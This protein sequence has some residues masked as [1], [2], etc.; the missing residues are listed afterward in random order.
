MVEARRQ[1]RGGARD[2]QR[3]TGTPPPGTRPGLLPEPAPQ[4]RPE[5]AARASEVVGLPTLSLPVLAEASG[6]AVD[7]S[8]RF[9]VQRM[10]EVLKKEEE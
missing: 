8:L 4:E 1:G 5:A 9:L 6:E 10:L 3:P 2:T 7:S